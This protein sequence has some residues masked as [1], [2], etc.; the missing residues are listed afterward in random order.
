MSG[1]EKDVVFPTELSSVSCKLSD[2]KDWPLETISE[3][4]AVILLMVSLKEMVK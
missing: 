1:H 4:K 3:N 2:L